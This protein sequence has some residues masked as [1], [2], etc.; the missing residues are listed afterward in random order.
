[1]K[2]KTKITSAITTLAIASGGL[3]TADYTSLENSFERANPREKQIIA[4]EQISKIKLKSFKVGDL[5]VDID[6]IE[7]LDESTV[8][9]K[10]SAFEN[11]KNLE[12]DNGV[13]IYRNMGIELPDGTTSK[14]LD[15]EGKL[16]DKKNYKI[17]VETALKREILQTINYLTK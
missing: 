2:L 16:V 12:I 7:R 15:Q 10:V 4:T 5:K 17:D 14:E 3:V 8:K 13:F 9:V 11:G 1:L 6:Q